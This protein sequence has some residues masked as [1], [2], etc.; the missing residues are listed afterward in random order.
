MVKVVEFLLVYN[1]YIDSYL[2]CQLNLERFYILSTS[3]N[4]IVTCVFLVICERIQ[5][6]MSQ[7]STFFQN[8][9]NYDHWT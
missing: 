5:N 4:L 3:F 6:H 1:D 8:N 2:C 7:L 9:N